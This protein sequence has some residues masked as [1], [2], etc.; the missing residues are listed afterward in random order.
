MLPLWARVDLGAVA[1]KG[2]STFPKAPALLEPRHHLVSYPGHS[3]GGIYSSPE[4][5]SV[6]STAPADW[7][8]V[9]CLLSVWMSNSLIWPI[10]RTLSS[11][12]SLSPSGLGNNGNEG[13]LHTPWNSKTEVSHSDCLMSYQGHSLVW[14]VLLLCR[15]PVGVFYS[16]SQQGLAYFKSSLKSCK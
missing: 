7:A 16:P 1:M 8:K 11:P 13:I 10:D 15:D 6:Y 2:Y 4:Q 12:T 5:Q 9:I 3:W 14:G